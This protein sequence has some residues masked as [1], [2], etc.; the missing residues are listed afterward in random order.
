MNQLKARIREIDQLMR[1]PSVKLD[2]PRALSPGDPWQEVTSRQ[3]DGLLLSAERQRLVHRLQDA[4]E[5]P[6]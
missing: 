2:R 4:G 6:M 3:Y 1:D 5:D